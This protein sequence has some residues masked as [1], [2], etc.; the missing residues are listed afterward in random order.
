M[1]MLM[2][3]TLMNVISRDSVCTASAI[4]LKA[5]FG[6]FAILASHCL[7]TELTALVRMRIK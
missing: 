7:L 1:L 6:A 4:T 5:V 2:F 3:Q